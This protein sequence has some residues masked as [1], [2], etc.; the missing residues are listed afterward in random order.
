MV[1][2]CARYF[3]RW[4]FLG[5]VCG[6]ISGF[7]CGVFLL[8]LGLA[9]E[10]TGRFS[11]AFLFLPAV[12]LLCTLVNRL[13]HFGGAPGRQGTE[14]LIGLYNST[15]RNASTKL[16]IGPIETL[17]SILTISFGG[18]AGKEGPSS[19]LAGTLCLNVA[20]LFRLDS[21]SSKRMLLCGMAGG[22]AAVFGTPVAAALFVIEIMVMG[23]PQIKALYPALLASCISI[24]ICRLLTLNNFSLPI[25]TQILDPL[26]LLLTGGC[27]L[28][29]ALFS[30]LYS[31]GMQGAQKL[32]RLLPVSDYL[33]SLLGGLC[34]IALAALCGKEYLGLGE[35]FF[36]GILIAGSSTLLAAPL[37][38][39]LFTAVTLNWGGVGGVITP[40]FF[41]GITAGSIFGQLISNGDSSQVVLFGAIGLVAMLASTCKTPLAAVV[42]GIE[43]FGA[44]GG[45]YFLVAAIAAYAASWKWSF[46]KTQ[47][48][49]DFR[50]GWI[51]TARA[52][53]R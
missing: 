8:V 50:A 27:A 4:T 12:F 25:E 51:Q 16:F 30:L 11:Y 35:P 21:A 28:L 14:T 15:E 53:R 6:G 36:E 13:G 44:S 45:I 52:K 5:A 20:R 7:A 19:F 34:I 38:K 9:V 49:P 26:T 18:S 40:M 43:L 32:N 31:V 29:L 10:L 1:L 46:F 48:R 22:F 33:K 17:L 47:I 2:R 39:I 3:L 41:I 42:L 23:R 37:L 24:L